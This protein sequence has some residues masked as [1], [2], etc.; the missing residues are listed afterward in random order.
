M[1]GLLQYLYPNQSPTCALSQVYKLWMLFNMEGSPTIGTTVLAFLLS[2]ALNLKSPHFLWPVEHA[3]CFSSTICM[4]VAAISPK[5]CVQSMAPPPSKPLLIAVFVS[6]LEDAMLK[7]L[8]T[9]FPHLLGTEDN[10][11]VEFYKEF[12]R[13]TSNHDREFIKKY[14]DDLSTTLIFAGLFSAVASAFIVSVE[15]SLQPDY[16]QLSYTVLTLMANISLGHTPPDPSAAFPQWTGPDPAIVHVEAILYSSLAASLLAALFAML[17]KQWLNRYSQDDP[18]DTIID[19]GRHRQ[20]KM[21]GMVTWR[22]DLVM[23]CLPLMLQAALLLLSCALSKYLFTINNTVAGVVVG[24]TSFGVLFYL[25]I[26]SA[27]TLSYNCP[28]QTPLS[29]VIRYMIRFDDEHRK[30]LRRFRKRFVRTFFKKRRQHRPRSNITHTTRGVN[31]EEIS[32]DVELTMENLDQQPPLFNETTDWPGF[33]LDS[34]CIAWMF[35]RSKDADV[36]LA[37][38][39]FV[40]EVVWHNGIRAIPLEILYD[41]LLRCFDQSR[42]LPV[43]IPRF[44]NKAYLSARA[45][46]HLVIQRKCIGDESDEAM[47]NYISERHSNIGSHHYEGDS[48]L[49]STLGIIDRIFGDPEEIRLHAPSFTVPHHAWEFARDSLRLEPP[50]PA[51]IVTDCLFIFGCNST[52]SLQ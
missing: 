19:R 50:P 2:E 3:H 46:L 36:M 52:A 28:F 44:R 15:T 17:G 27:A 29:L 30:Y 37:I 13:Q 34:N 18:H 32:G 8:S 35:D 23:E 26:V 48:D 5:A 42:E 25:L 45:F 51:P 16:T 9:L 11:R 10:A 31:T 1:C 14:D 41:N 47:F 49:E 39:K 33:V 38:T 6:S 20:R 43:V 7:A 21:N 12:Q 22:F 24:F 40:P 4:E